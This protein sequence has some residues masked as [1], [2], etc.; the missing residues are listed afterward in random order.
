MTLNFFNFE[1]GLDSSILFRLYELNS[2]DTTD[3]IWQLL[4]EVDEEKRN[5]L[6]DILILLREP[7]KNSVKVQKIISDMRGQVTAYED[8]P[9]DIAPKGGDDVS[10][11]TL[12]NFDPEITRKTLESKNFRNW[13]LFMHPDQ[14][15]YVEKDFNGP[16]LL[17]G[18]S[19]SGKTAVVV[20]RAI[21]LAKIKP[22][23]KV[24]VF[25]LNKALAKLIEDLVESVDDDLNNLSVMSLWPFCVQELAIFDPENPRHYGEET[26]RSR[27]HIDADHIDDVWQEFYHQE[28]RFHAADVLFPV[29]QSLLQ[30]NIN[31]E[32]YIREEFDFIRSAFSKDERSGYLSMSRDGRSFALQKNFREFILEGLLGWEKKMQIVGTI[33]YVGLTSKLYQYIDEIQPKYDSILV[34]EMQDLGTLELRIIRK[35][36]EEGGNDIFLAG[37]T[38]QRV[39]TKQH[40]FTKAGI[41]TLNRTDQINQNYRNTKEIL[42]AANNILQEN[43]TGTEN[44]LIKDIDILEPK[45]A[46]TSDFLP[47]VYKAESISKELTYALQYLQSQLMAE[48]NEDE[49]DQTACIAIAG[50]HLSELKPL[51][52][53]LRIQLLDGEIDIENRKIF[54]SDLE[55]TKGFEF[56]HMIIIN[57]T[58]GFLP[59][60]NLPQEEAFRDLSRFYVAMTR[61]RKN[62]IISY[63][64]ELSSFVKK[65][66]DDYFLTDDWSNQIELKN[67]P[68]ITALNETGRLERFQVEAINENL[69]GK[70]YGSLTGKELLLTRKA[71]GMSK[72]RQDK[73]IKYITGI[74]KRA[75]ATRDET[76][77]NLNDLFSSQQVKVNAILAGGFEDVKK[78]VDYFKK[79]FEIGTEFKV[80]P[81]K[82]AQESKAKPHQMES[83]PLQASSTNWNVVTDRSGKCMFCGEMA[84]PGDSVCYQCNPG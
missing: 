14:E 57:C 10:I 41:N 29:H 32:E 23:K 68:R 58:D 19:G 13:M 77:K 44:W 46:G 3:T 5:A 40:S 79:L 11:I 18:V 72:E 78:E 67:I 75:Q 27:M 25:T 16:F 65:S 42:D 38:A 8:A 39:L 80:I 66:V 7:N 17:K 4:L 21:R 20:N 64:N 61:A 60:P 59:N 6:F 71:I 15:G 48:A 37:D 36:V 43:I 31:P 53:D 35:L 28:L 33:D 51:A 63:H 56:D 74:R 54:L 73:L 22:D 83:N 62:L 84:I 81:K 55:Q 49:V 45:F 47:F 69:D 26:W 82:T 70:D 50:Y 76:W 52:H 12:G 30:N 2:M 1:I 24:M 34:D 9:K